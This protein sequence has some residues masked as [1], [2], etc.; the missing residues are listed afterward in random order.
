MKIKISEISDQCYTLKGFDNRG[1]YGCKCDDSCCKFGA[2]FDKTSFDLIHQH[3]ILVE[4]KLD[5]K[6]ENCFEDLFSNDKEFLGENSIRS[7]V[8]SNGF[9]VFHNQ[10]KKGCILYQIVDENKNVNRQL[11]PSICRLFPL[12]WNNGKLMIYSEQENSKIPDDCNCIEIENNS[13]K[14]ILETQKKELDDIIN[15]MN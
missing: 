7:L 8:G 2:D 5:I 15:R 9:C 6:I 1:C 11:I 4:E 14:N 13:T 10:N 3:R 12:S